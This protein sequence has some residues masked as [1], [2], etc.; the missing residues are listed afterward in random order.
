MRVTAVNKFLLIEELNNNKEEPVVFLPENVKVM[1]DRYR[2]FRF[3]DAAID[4]N[5][6]FKSME[7][8]KSI[9]VDT[10]M[11]EKVNI[12]LDKEVLFVSQNYVVGIVNE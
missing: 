11:I 4:C 8:G 1:S 2:I 7:S 12:S 5:D 3:V 6:V 10:T 9:I